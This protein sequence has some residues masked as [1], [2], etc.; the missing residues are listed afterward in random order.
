M[1]RWE[2]AAYLLT[3]VLVCLVVFWRVPITWFLNDDFAWLGLR[4]EINQPADL[5]HVLFGPKA[6]G[7][8]RFLSERLFFLSFS[9]LFG[10]HVLPYR[11]WVLGTWFADLTLASLIG[12]R[13]TGSRAAGLW[14][15]LL[16]TTSAAI[17]LPLDWAS[18]YNEVLCAFCILAA[19][20]A[21]LRW[22]ESGRRRWMITEWIFYLAGFGALE[23]VVMYPLI[24][25]VHAMCV[26]RKRVG[27]T[28]PL[29]VP[30]AAFAFLHFLLIPKS[31]GP[32]YTLQ[33]DQRLPGTLY[34]YL[35]W[36]LGPSR[37][38]DFVGRGRLAGLLF[39][40]AIGIT[41]LGFV[42]WRIRRREFIAVFC[43]GWFLFLLA[44]VLP[45]P[46]HITDYYVTVPMVGL[47][48]LGGW[49]M[50]TAWRG[51]AAARLAAVILAAGYFAGSV[52]EINA[53]TRWYM[54][55]SHRIRAVV[56]GMEEMTR[57]QPGVAFLLQGVD[58]PLFQSGF[59][60]DPFRLFGA[61]RVYFVPGGEKGIQARA[62]LGGVTRFRISPGQALDLIEHGQ[63]RVL[64]V[65]GG[66][67][68]DV[69]RNYETILR[70]DPLARRREFVDA[71]DP[72]YG[73]ALGTSW[74]PAEQGFRWM[75]RRA[76]VKLS[77]P[78]SGSEKLYITGYAPAAV[79]AG[80]PVTLQVSAAG[81]DL[82]TARISRPDQQFSLEFSLPPA[83]TGR[84]FIEI[85]I[86]VDKVLK[87]AGEIRELGM[88]FGT[89]GIH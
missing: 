54:E 34:T 11:L 88:V 61:Q 20:Y 46:D 28:L 82:G 9:S 51:S 15:A 39:T 86:E 16:W 60:D 23:I 85:A 25:T 19:F 22:L 84:E 70:S 1:K 77:G 38:G 74:Y 66:E 27:S 43:C 59:Q 2:R 31:A 57:A 29:F 30:A 24:A 12:A 78:M 48:W 49:A 45:L 65:S 37:L 3:P 36:A 63:A 40:I 80:G 42:L 67:P 17:V 35:I 64:N 55:R 62:D 44:P 68:R 79:L 53:I 33:V 73:S 72:L 52:A 18:S 4:L 47:A 87:P 21:R 75:P 58:N 89:F 81:K 7:T 26:A 76:T 6:Q 56:L 8:V 50:V 5:W 69:T 41:L 13:L 83:L 71:G 10:F 14:A 32:Y